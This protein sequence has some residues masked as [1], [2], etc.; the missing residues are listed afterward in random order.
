M[1]GRIIENLLGYRETAS[2]I[3]SPPHRQPMHQFGKI[4][5]ALG[6]YHGETPGE[7]RLA[8]DHAGHRVYIMMI[9]TAGRRDM[10]LLHEPPAGKILLDQPH[11]L[12]VPDQFGV[13][14]RRQL[15][16]GV[17]LLTAR[18]LGTDLQQKCDLVIGMTRGKETN[19]LDFFWG[20]A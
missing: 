7:T 8:P 2:I 15:F 3:P 9:V 19:Y 6:S 1:E 18:S 13:R 4:L 11:F 5:K 20:Q 12:R 17:P 14:T 16:H 10:S